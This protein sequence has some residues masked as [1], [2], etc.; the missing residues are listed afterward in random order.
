MQLKRRIIMVGA[1]FFLAAATGHLMQNGPSLIGGTEPG[2]TPAPQKLAA[3]SLDI[4]PERI[5]PLAGNSTAPVVP[6]SLSPAPS[7]PKMQKVLPSEPLATAPAPIDCTPVLKAALA[8]AAMV[9]LALSAPCNLN[10]R[11]VIRHSGL[12]IT[13]VTDTKGNLKASIPAMASAAHFTVALPDGAKAEADVAVPALA[14]YDRIAV[15]WQGDD[16]FQLHAFEFGADYGTAGHVSAETP[17]GP[18]FAVQATG[19]FLTAL[20]EPAVLLPMLAQVYTFPSAHSQRQGAVRLT[21]EAEVTA[22]TC[23][24][25]MLGETLEAHAGMPVKVVDLTLAMPGC[26]ATGDYVVLNNLLPDVN[27]ARN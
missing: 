7:A 16:A 2:V 4:A 15:Q 1:T 8:P 12:T 11:V 9:D 26:E 25:D 6:L 23:G 27:I 3:A 24:H 14:D 19:G 5:V 18:G 10:A 17:R 13:G 22:K 20:G 21:I